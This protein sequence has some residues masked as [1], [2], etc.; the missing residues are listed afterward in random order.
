MDAEVAGRLDRLGAVD[1]LFAYRMVLVQLL[2]ELTICEVLPAPPYGYVHYMHED[3][4]ARPRRGC[5]CSQL[6][7]LGSCRLRGCGR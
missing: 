6:R 5:V 7:M 3:K 2:R 4:R 1:C